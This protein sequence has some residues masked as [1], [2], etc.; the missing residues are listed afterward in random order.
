MKPAVRV[1][2]VFLG[3]VALLHLLRLL[4]GVGVTVDGVALPMWVSLFGV[5]GP[6]ALAVWL[7]WE[8]RTS[9]PAAT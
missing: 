7:G 6:G 1:T 2:L 8:Q 4:I 3:L 5:L 9:H